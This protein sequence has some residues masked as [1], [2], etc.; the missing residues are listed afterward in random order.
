MDLENRIAVIGVDL[1]CTGDDA[2]LEGLRLLAVNAVTKLHLLYVIDPKSIEVAYDRLENEE[3]ALANAPSRIEQRAAALSRVHGLDVSLEKVT[4][5]ARIG[6]PA[7]T[8]LQ[9]CVDYDADFLIVGTH[10]RTGIDRILDGSIAESVLRR[11]RCPVL[12]ARR[13]D[14]AG[15]ARTVLPD[16]PRPPGE[17]PEH[18]HGVAGHTYDSTTM[19]AWHPSDNGPT[20]F[21]I[22]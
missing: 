20:G 22:V 8:L 19:D 1:G 10:G 12:V 15:V 2:L 17:A 16:L 11:A 21:R 14:Y 13:K 7:A 18:A 5:H 4:G 6:D 3:R 9:M